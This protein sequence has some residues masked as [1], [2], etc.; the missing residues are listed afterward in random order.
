M[1]YVIHYDIAAVVVFT[2]IIVAFYGRRV[3]PTRENHSFSAFMIVGMAVAA[4]D[5][6]SCLVMEY[7]P[8]APLVFSYVLNILVFVSINLLYL[9]YYHYIITLTRNYKSKFW[10]V[11][12]VLVNAIFWMN[13]ILEVLTPWLHTVFYF[14]NGRYLHGKFYVVH[15]IS[16][17]VVLIICMIL[18][19][20]TRR[21]FTAV[22]NSIAY[23]GTMIFILAVVIQFIFPKYLLM[24]FAT[25]VYTLAVLLGLQNPAEFM[26]PNLKI[27]NLDALAA[28]MDQ[29][30]DEKKKFGLLVFSLEGL[31]FV[32]QF[33]GLDNSR[34][35]LKNVAKEC[36][37]YRKD[38]HIFYL[39]KENF[40]YF[41]QDENERE[42][43]EVADWLRWRFLSTFN[44]KGVKVNLTARVC[45]VKYSELG[46]TRNELINAIDY[47]LLKEESKFKDKLLWVES[48]EN[49]AF[50][51][52]GMVLHVLQKALLKK[53]FE[54]YYQPI[55]SVKSGKFVTAEALVRLRDPELG[56]ISP[57]EFIPIAERHGLILQIG[58]YVFKQVCE[59]IASGEV[60][61]RGIEYIE[62][63]LSM[64]QCMQKNL[65]EE[66][67]SIMEAYHVP[68]NM[69]DFEITE[70]F[71]SSDNEALVQNMNMLIS[72]GATFAADD[73]GTGF[74]TTTYL[75][76]Y[77]FKII[78]LDK[79]FIWKAMEDENAMKILKHTA[80]MIKSLN[81]SI[82]AEG[83]ETLE[84]AE[85]LKEMGVD[86][87]QGFYFSKP[88]S[89]E[90]FVKFI[91]EEAPKF[92]N[93]KMLP[94]ES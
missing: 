18:T 31:N 78:K 43:T 70:T 37:N 75:M 84:Q 87:L 91:D 45:G 19:F 10:V 66:I 69:L 47:T 23:F 94:G 49:D 3:I 82:V 11:T 80:A 27:Y 34:E 51:R 13:I 29:R 61:S 35:L 26:D 57:D 88:V 48:D 40:A 9:T 20:Y 73:F 2:F 59:F 52:E 21:K 24:P 39:G 32:D 5:L 50:R 46:C 86:F 64:V 90:D 74:A 58:E 8:E 67:S 42:I 71:S 89:R 1:Q 12:R 53:E 4:L 17:G 65:Y 85:I 7:W 30:M 22:Q 76:E 81:M 79:S 92:R 41:F 60:A 15:F 63:N 28:L 38:L 68:S 16:G 25:S 62:V 77:P 33:M 6:L 14:E 54:V 36:R 56:F 83:V 44:I 72:K 93:L 55:Y